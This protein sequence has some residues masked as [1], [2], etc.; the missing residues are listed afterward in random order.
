[1]NVLVILCGVAIVGVALRALASPAGLFAL[2]ERIAR[3]IDEW[4]ARPPAFVRA[5]C[6]F[7]LAFGALVVV[8]GT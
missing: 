2:R 1:M 3:R 5:W 4:G 8:A 6:A 7:A